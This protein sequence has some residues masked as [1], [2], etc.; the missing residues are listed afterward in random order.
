MRWAT[1]TVATPGPRLASRG[2]G[3]SPPRPRCAPR[4]GGCARRRVRR[5][6]RPA[7]PMAAFHRLVVGSGRPPVSTSPGSSPSRSAPLDAHHLA[8]GEQAEDLAGFLAGHE[9]L[10]RFVAREPPSPCP[11]MRLC[12]PGAGERAGQPPALASQAVVKDSGAHSSDRLGRSWPPATRWRPPREETNRRLSW[13]HRRDSNPGPQPYQG[14]ALP[15]SYGGEG[16]RYNQ[17]PA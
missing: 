16:A 9:A 10:K 4:S 8:L 6:R 11:R 5:A 17:L 12:D 1:E 14:C 13:C 7:H 3:G 2:R 15:L